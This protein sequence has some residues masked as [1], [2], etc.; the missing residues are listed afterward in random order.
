[1]ERERPLA[2]RST[3]DAAAPATPYLAPDRAQAD[4]PHFIAEC[5]FIT[6]RLLRVGIIPSGAPE[7]GVA[8]S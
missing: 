5:F 3:P 8:N 2:E 1:M 4:A 6:Q 7:P